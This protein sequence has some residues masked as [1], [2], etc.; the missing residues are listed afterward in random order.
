MK[1]VEVRHIDRTCLNEKAFLKL[2]R[3]YA[4]LKYRLII[5]FDNRIKAYG[6]YNFNPTK[7]IHTIKI[8]P[9]RNK[10][11]QETSIDESV[12]KT[13]TVDSNG[14]KYQLISTTLHEL[15]HALQKEERGEAFW[16]KH[17]SEATEIKDIS[18]ADF[19]SEC[20][21]EA[22]TFEHTNILRSCGSIQ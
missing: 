8:S 22:R 10:T 15:K 13:K 6:Q 4:K 17:Y 11:I 21:T 5:S 12:C 18:L 19:Y 9:K 20:E 3:K 7:R 1:K 2:V 16:N 14:E